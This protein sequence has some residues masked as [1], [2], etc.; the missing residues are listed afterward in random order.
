MR[1]GEGLE[2]GVPKKEADGGH[3]SLGVTGKYIEQQCRTDFCA[4]K[5]ER[6]R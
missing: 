6:D 2:S 4:L 5:Y 1:D 3:F